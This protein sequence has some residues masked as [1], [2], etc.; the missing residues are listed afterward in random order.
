[1]RVLLLIVLVVL[2]GCGRPVT[3]DQVLHWVPMG[4]PLAS[5]RLAMEQQGF[6]C[7]VLS[8]EQY[9]KQE[10]GLPWYGVCLNTTRQNGESL[11]IATNV[12]YL[13]CERGK[14]RIMVRLADDKSTGFGMRQ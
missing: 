3:N 14:V 1:M 2:V 8:D 11:E 4:A 5:A 9:K 12:C 6:T 10:D 13:A 7:T